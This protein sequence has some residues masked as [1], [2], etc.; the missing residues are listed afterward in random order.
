[1]FAGE[2]AVMSHSPSLWSSE[3]HQHSDVMFWH[4]NSSFPRSP[5]VTLG[6]HWWQLSTVREI[7]PWT[8]VLCLGWQWMW[9][10]LTVLRQPDC[11][12]GFGGLRTVACCMQ[13][14]FPQCLQSLLTPLS[15]VLLLQLA[16]SR[17]RRDTKHVGY[18]SLNWWDLSR[19]NAF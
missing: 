1:M 13:P 6:A 9:Q 15:I 5:W 4:D 14:H 18:S 2:T 7:Q 8:F 19:F 11:H 10:Q 3:S 12:V 16:S 17:W